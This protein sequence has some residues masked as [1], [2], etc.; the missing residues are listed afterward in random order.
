MV[1]LTSACMDGSLPL[2]IQQL[3][4]TLAEA[5]AAGKLGH[6]AS[7]AFWF[8]SLPEG[9]WQLPQ[10]W[11]SKRFVDLPPIQVSAATAMASARAA[12]V[13]ESGRVCSL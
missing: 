11:A 9:F 6:A 7:E 1:T 5:A 13:L 3:Q 2:A 10:D 12:Y 4:S 8:L